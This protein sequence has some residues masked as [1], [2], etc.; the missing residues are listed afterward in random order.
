[1]AK[2]AKV[3]AKAARNARRLMSALYINGMAIAVAAVGII[4]VV[5]DEDPTRW[6]WNP[7]SWLDAEDFDNLKILLFACTLSAGLHWFARRRVA[8]MED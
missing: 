8:E 5:M 2:T 4:P 6:T 1:M 3:P 7:R